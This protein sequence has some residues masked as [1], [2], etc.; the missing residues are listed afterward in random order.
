VISCRLVNPEASGV[1]SKTLQIAEYYTPIVQI[2]SDSTEG[3]QVHLPA[4]L[5]N[6]EYDVHTDDL[7][8]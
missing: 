3:L 8:S 6:D 2:D 5:F 7:Y 1:F 4:L